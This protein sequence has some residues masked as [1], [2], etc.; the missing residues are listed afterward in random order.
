MKLLVTGNTG[1]IG[2]LVLRHM[3]RALPDISIVGY[4][5]GYFAHCLTGAPRLPE[6]RLQ[7][8]HW[9]DVRDFPA[10]LFDGVDEF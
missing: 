1:Y 10:A 6:T 3:Q 8:Q 7:A 2:P 5:S 9:G 4:D